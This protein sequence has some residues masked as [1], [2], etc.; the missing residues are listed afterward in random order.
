MYDSQK[1]KE[2]E[3]LSKM[4]IKYLNDNYHPHT[5][6]IISTDSAEILEGVKAMQTSEFIRD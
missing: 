1:D 4:F 3:Q 6:I 2:F 5:K